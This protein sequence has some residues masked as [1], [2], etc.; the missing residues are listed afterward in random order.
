MS[1]TA[2]AATSASEI[3]QRGLETLVAESR[4]MVAGRVGHYEKTVT[5]SS[6]GAEPI[7]LTWRVSAQLEQPQAIK[8]MPPP[9]PIAFVRAEQSPL[10]PPA[11][12]MPNSL[13]QGDLSADGVAVLFYQ[14][15]AES[16]ALVL[17]GGDDSSVRL[18]LLKEIV[19]I[20]AMPNAA[21]QSAAWLA[22]LGRNRSDEARRVALRS[23]LHLDV[24]WPILAPAAERLM[25][26]P[27]TDLAT[28]SFLF[29]IVTFALVHG[30][31]AAQRDD[32]ARFL[33][34]A[35]LGAR[36]DRLS[37]QYLLQLKLLLR[38][39]DQEDMRQ[40]RLPLRQQIVAALKQRATQGNMSP[41]LQEQYRQIRATH[42][43]AY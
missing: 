42:P 22:C 3:Y 39:A 1:K 19:A 11:A 2:Y 9:S 12:G 27:S 15:A 41:E 33:C 10:L 13:E 37:L 5:S 29:G 35:F 43:E 24:A 30:R 21:E 7:P 40:K 25:A 31:F 32:A 14:G 8:G 28:R 36:D 20:Q 4:V 17:P 23:L 16:P 18:E 26:D 6:A 34:Q 38:Y